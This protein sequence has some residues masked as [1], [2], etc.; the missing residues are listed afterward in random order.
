[1]DPARL[2]AMLAMLQAAA[3]CD[4][5][6]AHHETSQ[7]FP[8]QL[9]NE[10]THVGAEPPSGQRQ[11]TVPTSSQSTLPPFSASSDASLGPPPPSMPNDNRRKRAPA[12]R[13]N[14]RS[15]QLRTLR[16]W[17]DDHMDDP[18]PTP[19]EKAILA[20]EVGMEVKQIE[21]W[22]TNRRKRHWNRPSS[23]HAMSGEA[24]TGVNALLAASKT[25]ERDSAVD[26]EIGQEEEEEDDEDEEMRYER[27]NMRLPSDQRM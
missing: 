18:Y 19:R 16:R 12:R 5:P 10:Y 24:A 21:H 22:F 25:S 2:D 4:S 15:D 6:S 20:I 1:V 3:I 13:R 14:H 7:H 23:P 17:F 11:V 9:A 27:E 26:D 8:A